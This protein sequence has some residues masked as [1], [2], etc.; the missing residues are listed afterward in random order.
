MRLN[1]LFVLPLL[2]AGQG[3][4]PSIVRLTHEPL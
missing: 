2:L 3:M 4:T 1:G